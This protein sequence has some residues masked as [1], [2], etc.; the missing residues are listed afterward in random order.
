MTE[1]KTANQPFQWNRQSGVHRESILLSAAPYQ[2]GRSAEFVVGAKNLAINRVRWVISLILVASLAGPVIAQVEQDASAIAD[3]YSAAMQ[4]KGYA[5]LS[6]GELLRRR[7]LIA[8]FTAKHLRQ[9]L[10]K[11][12]R[13]AILDGIDRCI[14]RLYSSPAGTVAYG[15]G[16]GS[17]GEEWMYLNDRDYL[18]TFQYHLWVA[19]TRQPLAPA[20]VQRRETQ[21][22][23]MRQYLTNLPFR[24]IHETPPREGMRHDEV[25]PWAMAELERAFA[26]PMHLL[27]EPLPDDGFSKLQ[28][29]FK[30]GSNG[31][32]ADFHDMEVAALTSRFICHK[33]PAG[34]Y[35]YTYTGQLPFD[36]TVVDLWGNGPSLHFASNADFRGNYGGLS[37]SSVYDVVRC[38]GMHADPSPMPPGAAMDA[39]L[40]REGR[41]DLTLD[42]ST[43][44]AVRGAKIANVPVKNWFDADKLSDDQLRAV[45]RNDGHDRISIKGLP[46][47]NGP[48][49]G[50]RTEGEFFIVVQTRDKRLAIINL[51]AYEFKQLMFWCRPR[52]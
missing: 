13:V 24:G 34:R 3:R 21:H 28:E 2:S 15:N 52:V 47:M 43:L 11:I 1:N 4:R 9:P 40:A 29:R 19:L 14:D 44:I 38:V 25:C 39:W 46:T 36:D 16:F 42:D 5:F 12:T 10:D 8:A 20:D 31:I 33:D 32:V 48:H 17:G 30:Q 41:G 7:D 18:L 6:S 50:D 27:A 26:D 37:Q 35:G 51:Y 23:W 45:I 22:N 49:R